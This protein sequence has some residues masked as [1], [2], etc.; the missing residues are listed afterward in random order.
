MDKRKETREVKKDSQQIQKV[1]GLTPVCIP[2]AEPVAFLA[3]KYHVRTIS[4][5]N[6][7]V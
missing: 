6:R 7:N 3:L 4:V 5:S 1:T 2:V